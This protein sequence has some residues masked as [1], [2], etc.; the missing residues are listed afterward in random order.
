M[1]WTAANQSLQKA[2]T[3][4]TGRARQPFD[5][6]MARRQGSVPADEMHDLCAQLTEIGHALRGVEEGLNAVLDEYDPPGPGTLLCL[7]RDRLSS[8]TRAP[9]GSGSPTTA[10]PCP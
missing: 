7:L 4:W 8:E 1:N 10:T 3:A 2:A 9:R 6:W 5:T